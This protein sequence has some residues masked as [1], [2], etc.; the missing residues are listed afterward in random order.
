[1]YGGA[2]NQ[3]LYYTFEFRVVADHNSITPTNSSNL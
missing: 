2:Q 1:M 3:A